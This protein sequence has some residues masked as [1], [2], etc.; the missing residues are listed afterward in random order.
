M[1]L[2]V[3]ELKRGKAGMS[4]VQYQDSLGMTA[5]CT[6]RLLETSIADDVDE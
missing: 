5:A 4:N 3:F 2:H 1:C 6:A